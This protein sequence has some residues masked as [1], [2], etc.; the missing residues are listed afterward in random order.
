VTPSRVL[1]DGAVE[2][3]LSA[4]QLEVLILVACGL[5]TEGIACELVVSPSTVRAHV[6]NILTALRARNRAHAV[7]IAYTTGLILI[8]DDAF[9]RGNGRAEA[10]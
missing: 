7:A 5:S 6:R 4:R 9:P 10:T 1:A 3:V 8:G 2:R